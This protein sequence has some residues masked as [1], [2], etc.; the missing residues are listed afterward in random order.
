MGCVLWN[1]TTG[2][3]DAGNCVEACYIDG[4][5]FVDGYPDP[6]GCRD[7]DP[8][9]SL[10]AI[11]SE[12]GVSPAAAFIEL[13][14]ESDGELV[15]NMPFLNQDLAAVEAMLDDLADYVVARIR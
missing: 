11:A 7:C 12:R 3:C 6:N 9:T 10:A 13:L 4:T 1:G 2:L 5:S 14:L 8:A 15:A